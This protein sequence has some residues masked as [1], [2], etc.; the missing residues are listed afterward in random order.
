M[1]IDIGDHG[2]PF[3]NSVGVVNEGDVDIHHKSLKVIEDGKPTYASKT[4]ADGVGSKTVVEDGIIIM[5]EDV[6]IDISSKISNTT[7]ADMVSEDGEWVWSRF[8]S[9]LP[10]DVLLKIVATKGLSPSL[11][12]GGVG[13]NVL[14]RSLLLRDL[15]IKALEARNVNGGLRVSTLFLLCIGSFRSVLGE[16]DS[17]SLWVYVQHLRLSCGVYM[18]DSCLLG[19]DSL[20]VLRVLMNSL[21]WH[22]NLPLLLHVERLRDRDWLIQFKHVSR[23]ANT[24]ANALAKLASSDRLKVSRFIHPTLE[25]RGLLLEDLARD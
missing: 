8:Q 2:T 7:V 23:D 10:I 1:A 22:G 4:A 19:I 21:T 6:R 11:S 18:L 17:R 24:V 13:W 20:D 5:E 16:G 15:T 3:E 12:N 25:I 9:F 14:N